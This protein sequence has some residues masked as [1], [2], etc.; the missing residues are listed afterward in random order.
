MTYVPKTQAYNNNIYRSRTIIIID[1]THV[2][3]NRRAGYHNIGKKKRT[4]HARTKTT[5]L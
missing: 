1:A 5:E 2:A 3:N 4:R